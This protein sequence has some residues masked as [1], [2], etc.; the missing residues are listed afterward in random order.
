MTRGKGA[1]FCPTRGGVAT[2][3]ARGDWSATKLQKTRLEKHV[4]KTIHAKKKTPTVLFKRRWADFRTC[5]NV[6]LPTTS[7]FT[8]ENF[9]ILYTLLQI[10]LEDLR[11]LVSLQR[12]TTQVETKDVWER[13]THLYWIEKRLVPS[14]AR[15]QPW[16]TPLPKPGHDRIWARSTTAPLHLTWTGFQLPQ[17]RSVSL[18][19]EN[20]DS[21]SFKKYFTFL[22]LVWDWLGFQWG[23][24]SLCRLLLGSD[25]FA[26]HL[27]FWNVPKG[28]WVV[29]ESELPRGT[30]PAHHAAPQSGKLKLFTRPRTAKQ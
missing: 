10:Y 11:L 3:P 18:S 25:Q 2:G 22:I 29:P 4:V 16:M 28:L 6:F 19:K 21:H 8:I 24:T 26:L 1:S 12:K 9:T 7:N 5:L 27:H 15:T 20:N 14:K 30:C 13:G 23:N 17:W